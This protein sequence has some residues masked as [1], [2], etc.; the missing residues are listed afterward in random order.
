MITIKNNKFV[1]LADGSKKDKAGFKETFSPLKKKEFFIKKPHY[2][3]HNEIKGLYLTYINPILDKNKIKA[4]IVIDVP[5]NFLKEMNKSLDLLKKYILF[6]MC[7]IILISFFIV[8]FAYLDYKREKENEFLNNELLKL[9]KKLSKKIEEK[10]EE[11]REKDALLLHQSKLASLGEMLNMIAH[12]WRQP[13]N[14]LSA[15]AIKIELLENLGKIKK[16]DCI[17]FSKMV[18]KNTQRLSEIINDFMKLG[19]NESKK[20]K[21]FMKEFLNKVLDI[22]KVQLENHNIK[23]IVKS[24]DCICYSYKKELTHVLLNLISNARD[25]LD[26]SDIKEK[27][28]KIEAH[29]INGNKCIISVENPGEIPENIQQRLFEPYFTTKEEGKGTGLGLY[30]SK[31]IV[32]ELLKGKIYFESKE[33]K[34]RFIIELKREEII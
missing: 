22:V 34:T 20:E 5:L 29:S 14:A 25:A 7:F 2:F 6:I 32:E 26:E 27:Y 24:D 23:L 21:F 33:G 4:L 30:I 18:Q 13:L 15:A 9:N 31:K 3:F 17:N 8:Y 16:E 1:F 10:V 12:Q 19:K 11:L 28:I